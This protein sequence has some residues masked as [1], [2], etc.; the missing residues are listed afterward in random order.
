[1]IKSFQYKF[2]Q[3]N[4]IF[5]KYYKNQFISMTEN[6]PLFYLNETIHPKN[7]LY[8]KKIGNIFTNNYFGL[9]RFSGYCGI[10]QRLSAHRSY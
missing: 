7:V 8:L 10:K 1:M 2:S 3:E 4:L 6:D 5:P 9:I